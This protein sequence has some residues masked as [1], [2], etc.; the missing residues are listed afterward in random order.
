MAEKNPDDVDIP[1][2]PWGRPYH[3]IKP[4]FGGIKGEVKLLTLGAD[5][6]EGGE[7]MNADIGNW[8]MKYIDHSENL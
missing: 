4:W 3:Y 5:G 8:Q 2:D 7:N 6:V 1:N